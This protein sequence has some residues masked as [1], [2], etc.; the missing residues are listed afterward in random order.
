MNMLVIHSAQT[1]IVGKNVY[2]LLSKAF[3]TKT[4]GTCLFLHSALE[5]C[6]CSTSKHAKQ[7]KAFLHEC[8]TALHDTEYT[9]VHP[10]SLHFFCKFK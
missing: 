1:P 3:C 9:S 8:T 7:G 2:I 10:Y 4:G 6:S 5:F